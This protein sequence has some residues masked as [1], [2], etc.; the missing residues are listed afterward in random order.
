MKRGH[1][2]IQNKIS[3][4]INGNDKVGDAE[5]NISGLLN[6]QYQVNRC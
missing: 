2:F 6:Y 5:S 4:N 1:R 3:S